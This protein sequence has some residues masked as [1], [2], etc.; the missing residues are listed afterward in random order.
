MDTP[1]EPA[2]DE[3]T[4]LAARLCDT[5]ISL[6]SLVDES[7]QWFK[8]KVGMV[9]CQ[10]PRDQA[11]CGYVVLENG[12]LIVTNAAVDQR[13]Y[14]NALVTGPPGIR[15]YAGI[16]LRSAEGYALGALCVIDLHPRSLTERQLADLIA[17]ARQAETQL[18]Y[19]A[20]TRALSTARD[21]MASASSAKSMFVATMSHEIR[22]PLTAIT[23]FMDLLLDENSPEVRAEYAATVRTNSNLLMNI[24]NDAL[25][26]AKIENGKLTIE[27]AQCQTSQLLVDMER[28]FTPQVQAKGIGLRIVAETTIPDMFRSDPLRVRQVLVNLL[29]NAIK[30]TL[31]GEVVLAT[32]WKNGV[33]A[34]EVR[35]SGIGMTSEQ[36]SSLFVPFAQASDDTWRKFGGTGLG[37]T[38]SKS[39][40]DLLGGS[41]N[42]RS[43]PGKG[44]IFR[45]EVPAPLYF[46]AKLVSDWREA[47]AVAPKLA[48]LNG[49]RVL[50]VEDGLDNQRLI[51][52]FLERAGAT[53]LLATDGRMGLDLALNSPEPIDLV[54]MDMHLPILDGVS[55]TRILRERG[56]T[57]PILSITA[58]AVGN[59]RQ[60]AIDAGC[61]DLLAKPF[62]R[63]TFLATCAKWCSRSR[64]SEAA[65]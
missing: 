9:T 40:A 49:R 42:V 43:S 18:Q 59:A 11:F 62:E 55:A 16:P 46:G 27:S 19:R 7:R 58:G 6:I 34:F 3:L 5:P 4:E 24:V 35:D 60:D 15:F 12:P 30:F 61:D 37:L 2:F 47:S 36:Q 8:S 38:I 25:D 39:L 13:F 63:T 54:L 33:L 22:T 32:S 52:A 29:S 45:F 44:T 10:T 65:A 17:L 57:A 1:P 28:L 23:G 53:V 21:A 26:I 48:H 14:D 64:S 31:Q 56:F 20:C 50:V 41:L 51:R